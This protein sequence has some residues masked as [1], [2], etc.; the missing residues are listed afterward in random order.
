MVLANG[1]RCQYEPVTTEPIQDIKLA[2]AALVI[3]LEMQQLAGRN[4]EIRILRNPWVVC[5]IREYASASVRGLIPADLTPS[6]GGWRRRWVITDMHCRVKFIERTYG[7]GIADVSARE[8]PSY[9]LQGSLWT[10]VMIAGMPQWGDGRCGRRGRLP[11]DTCHT[12]GL[13]SCIANGIALLVWSG[14]RRRRGRG[15]LC[16]TASWNFTAVDSDWLW[17]S[18][19]APAVRLQQHQSCNDDG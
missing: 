8:N 4:R 12:H 10:R 19:R 18:R 7:R 17:G 13:V 1:E 5:G 16:V 9:S 11:L 15:K 3:D 14:R 2:A 6:V